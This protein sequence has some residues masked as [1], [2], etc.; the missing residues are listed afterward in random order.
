[1]GGGGAL[2]IKAVAA[3]SDADTVDFGLGGSNG[4]N[5]AGVGNFT[6]RRNGR[7]GNKEDGIGAGGHAGAYALVKA[8]AS[9]LNQVGP[10]G[11]RIR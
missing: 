1:M 9:A 11:R 5:H 10:S 8:S 6:V 7:F 2:E 3:Y 4:G